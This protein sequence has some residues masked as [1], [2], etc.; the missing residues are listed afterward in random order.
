MLKIALAAVFALAATACGN[1]MDE[2]VDGL[3]SWATKMCACTDKACADK[4]HEDYKK[5]E[6]DVLE[7][8][9]KGSKKEDIDKSTMEKAE[10]ADKKRKEC[11][12]K[13]RDAAPPAPTP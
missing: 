6:N 2:V 11:R 7:P 3:D 1:K 5:W 9:M 8:K 4:T 10:A 12:R 13:F